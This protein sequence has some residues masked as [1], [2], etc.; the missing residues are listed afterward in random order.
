MK[1][2]LDFLVIGAQKSGTT[3]LYKLLREHPDIYLPKEKELAFFAIEQR[4]QQGFDWLLEEYFSEAG[5]EKVW[6]DVSPQHMAGLF[7]AGRIAKQLPAIKM[8]AVLRNPIY[9]AYSAYRMAVRRGQETRSLADIVEQTK[10]STPLSIAEDEFVEDDYIRNGLYGLVLDRYMQCF[11]PKQIHV[12]FMEEFEN[13]PAS[14]IEGI[15]KFLEVR[16]DFIPSSLGK[17]FH[18]GGAVR[19]RWLVS[20]LQVG[21]RLVAMMPESIR[22]RLR[23]KA[24]WINQWNI[25]PEN[26][27]PLAGRVKQELGKIFEADVRRLEKLINRRVPWPEFQASED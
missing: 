17:K 22:R 5:P 25:K 20:L 2:N 11:S 18:Q 4:Y 6:G 23:G 13:D 9:R 21:R 7:V 24:Y 3:T 16:S 14:T 8:V 19:L 1:K 10:Q 26:S 27:E 15:F 12:V